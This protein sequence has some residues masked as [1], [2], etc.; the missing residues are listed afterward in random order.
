V[1]YLETQLLG[2][3]RRHVGAKGADLPGHCNHWHFGLRPRRIGASPTGPLLIHALHIFQINT[4]PER[5]AVCPDRLWSSVERWTDTHLF[6]L[7]IS[8]LPLP[9]RVCGSDSSINLFMENLQQL[10]LFADSASRR[11]RG[12]RQTTDQPP[13]TATT[14]SVLAGPEAKKGPST[15]DEVAPRAAYW[16]RM[17]FTAQR[18]TRNRERT[19][20]GHSKTRSQ[21]K[22]Q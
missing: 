7:Y 4:I 9:H 16:R 21:C 11:G 18:P 6:S 8:M 12:S 13:Q 1:N 5:Y 22:V 15:V 20:S 19:G 14:T 3:T 10:C 17:A 2:D